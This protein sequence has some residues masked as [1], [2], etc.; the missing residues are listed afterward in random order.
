MDYSAANAALW[1]PIIQFGVIAALILLANLLRRKI[2]FIRRSLMPT[3]V[4]AGFMMLLL[5]STGILKTNTEFLETLTYHA[6]CVGFIALTLRIPE[7]GSASGGLI[8]SKSGALIVSTYLVQ[9]TVGLVISLILAY[10]FMPDFFKAAGILLPMGYGQGPGQANN[11]GTTYEALGMAGGRSFGLSLA[12]AGYLC[13]CVVGVVFMNIYSK[14]GKVKRFDVKEELAGSVTIDS[15]QSHNEIPISESIDRLSIQVALIFGVYLLTYL[16]TWGLTELLALI[17]PGLAATVS[18]LLWGFNFIIGSLIAMIV[19]NSMGKFKKLKVMTRQYQNNYLMSRIS[20]L[21]FDFMIVAGIASI[22]IND[23]SGN[24]LP[25]LLMV[26]GGGVATYAW[27]MF[28]C[29][30]IYPD[31][32]YEGFFSMYGMLTGTI[33]S[34]VLLLRE[35]DPELKTPAANNLVTGSSFGIAFGAPVLLLVSLAS[36][37]DVM[38]FVTLGIIFV[39]FAILVSYIFLVGKKKAKK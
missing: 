2:P 38:V 20:G 7:E 9:A 31:Y 35:I 19:R 16:A 10:T 36:K 32:P 4:L 13:A 3:A 27:L 25:F 17:S 28:M 22:N 21:A 14:Q 11:V 15:F 12:A 1:E 39:Y 30:K 29:R 24:W 18:T 6:I 37:G 33:S 5:R 23:L 26:V 34:G 8:G